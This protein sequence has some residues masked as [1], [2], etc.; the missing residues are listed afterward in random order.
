MYVTDINIQDPGALTLISWNR[1]N[2]TLEKEIFFFTAC[3]F[4]VFKKLGAFLLTVLIN[5]TCLIRFM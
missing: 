3:A 4:F 2:S 5:A 1:K